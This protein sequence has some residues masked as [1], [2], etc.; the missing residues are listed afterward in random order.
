MRLVSLALHKRRQRL[1]EGS[2]ALSV[3]RK[4]SYLVFVLCHI[5]S[6]VCRNGTDCDYPQAL[7]SSAK[8]LLI[9]R[10]AGAMRCKLA[11]KS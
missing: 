1:G 10:D 5:G 7:H 9:W 4:P 2:E 11:R 3:G 6:I 8:R